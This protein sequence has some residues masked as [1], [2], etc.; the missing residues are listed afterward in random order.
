MVVYVRFKS[1]ATTR[2][3]TETYHKQS[4]PVTVLLAL[5]FLLKYVAYI[6]RARC[7]FE[8]FNSIL[9]LRWTG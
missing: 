9:Y 4:T 5:A 1:S 8:L 7:I 2:N 3:Y 6:V